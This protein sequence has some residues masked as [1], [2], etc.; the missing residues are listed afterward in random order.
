MKRLFCYAA[1]TVLALALTPWAA[2]QAPPVYQQP[3]PE[4]DVRL[5]GGKSQ[6]DEI[7]KAD[8]AKDLKDAAHL[9]DL[10]EQLKMELEK[11]DRRVL[12]ISS[13]KKTEEIE[14][15]AKRIRARLVH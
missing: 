15:L 3:S 6:Q 7:L 13:L 12:S 11:N 2:P 1:V 5:P 10:A 8:H 4:V 14:K 9:V